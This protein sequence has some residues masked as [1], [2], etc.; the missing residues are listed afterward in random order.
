MRRLSKPTADTSDGQLVQRFAAQRDESAF[1]ALLQ[2]HGP[3]VLGVCRRVLDDPADAQ[4]AFQATFLVLVRRAGAIRKPASVGSWLHGVAARLARRARADAARRRRHESRA[5]VRSGED[6]SAELAESDFRPVLDEELGRLPEKYRAPLV[7]CYLEGKTHTEAAQ[8][9]GWAHGTVCGRLARARALLRTR[10]TRRGLA[11]AVLLG[12]GASP[13]LLAAVPPA[14]AA[15]TVRLAALL[16]APEAAAAGLSVQVAALMEGAVR[17][18]FLTKLKAVAV[19]LLAVGLLTTGAGLLAHRVLAQKPGESTAPV[20]PA[21]AAAQPRAATPAV[22]LDAYGDPLPEGA[23]VRLG[24]TR[25]RHGGAVG[26]L[27]FTPDGKTLVAEGSDGA[28]SWDVATGQ[29]RHLFTDENTRADLAPDGKLL[30]TA[31]KSGIS[32]WEVETARLVRTLGTELYAS[33]C[34]SSDGRQLASVST[35]RQSQ[36]ALWDVAAGRQLRSFGEDKGP[37]A[38]LAFLPDGKSLLTTGHRNHNIRL[39]DVATGNEQRHIDTG[40]SDL[41]TIALS[42]DGSTLAGMA[43]MYGHEGGVQVWD[44]AR[45]TRRYELMPPGREKAV[46]RIIGIV[47]FT[48]DGKTLISGN[49]DWGGLIC[50]DLAT[51]TEQRRLGETVFGYSLAFAPDRRTLALGAA[52]SIRLLDTA[53][54]KDR[55]PHTGHG[56]PINQVQ[57]TADGRTLV[58]A[59]TDEIMVWDA[60]TGTER[61]RLQVPGESIGAFYPL[62]DGRTLL[63]SAYDSSS[64]PV[65]LRLWDLTTGKEARRIEP[66]LS[67]MI[68]P[69]VLAPDGKT[70]VWWKGGGELLLYDLDARR[71][72]RRIDVPGGPVRLARFTPDGRRLIFWDNKTLVHQLDVATGR[73]LSQFAYQDEAVL[74][75]LARA[76]GGDFRFGYVAEVAPDGKSIALACQRDRFVS[77]YDLATG[78]LLRL[79]GPLPDPGRPVLPGGMGVVYH[80]AFSP[81]GTTL[82]WIGYQ[83][84]AV[85][86]LDAATGQE[87]QQFTAHPGGVRALAFA[88][89]GKRLVTCG[90][91]T[92]ALIWDLTGRALKRPGAGP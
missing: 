31:G 29:Q 48:P 54:G 12:A 34:F 3:M 50:W 66:P 4:D 40:T 25:L 90:E 43:G 87:R 47:A 39:W 15:S 60:A 80:L 64:Q 76:V 38:R 11:P 1:E 16:A 77:L 21:Q 63:S 57:F 73:E 27:R 83:D 9:L 65:P 5:P 22:R 44:L 18:M 13:D 6:G 52:G 28:R 88:P 72:L 71:E 24:T 45:G 92:T 7:L 69:M 37:F 81:D 32:L 59:S 86:L 74:Q 84:P 91:D 26:F 61:H 14:L 89:D 30:A 35:G 17:A 41:L 49:V 85:H 42:P 46:R 10:L 78:R 75:D 62:S 70:S 33:I 56:M 2:R 79:L 23:L 19:V 20:A 58:T 55:F 53:S 67:G 68:G 36:I 51:G 8:E 82:A